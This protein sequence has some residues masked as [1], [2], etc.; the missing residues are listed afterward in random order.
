MRP[1]PN[2]FPVDCF[3]CNERF[4]L[5]VIDRLTSE[6]CREYQDEKP[7]CQFSD[8]VK[9]AQ[10]KPGLLGSHQAVGS[11][12]DGYSKQRNT[13]VMGNTSSPL[14]TRFALSAFSF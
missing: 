11:E 9:S 3:P 6:R 14:A 2:R 8:K 4:D 1:Y 7:E 5:S 12:V 13:E 10:A